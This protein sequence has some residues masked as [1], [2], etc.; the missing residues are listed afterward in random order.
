VS[1][2]L[3]IRCNSCQRAHLIKIRNPDTTQSF[4][5]VCR[6]SSKLTGTYENGQLIVAD[7]TISERNEGEAVYIHE[8]EPKQQ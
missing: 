3:I 7:A 1:N 8:S 5:F 4:S 6:C 2:E